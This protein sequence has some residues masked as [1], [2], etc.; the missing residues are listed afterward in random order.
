MDIDSKKVLL[1]PWRVSR[2]NRRRPYR[3]A[4]EFI[5]SLLFQANWV[6]SVS[7]DFLPSCPLLPPPLPRSRTAMNRNGPLKIPKR[8][9]LARA[10]SHNSLSLPLSLFSSSEVIERRMAALSKKKKKYFVYLKTRKIRRFKRDRNPLSKMEKFNRQL[11]TAGQR[12][13]SLF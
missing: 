4:Q 9:V 10:P 3:S 11:G 12:P 13:D 5:E 2:A 1:E 8:S 6:R 7:I